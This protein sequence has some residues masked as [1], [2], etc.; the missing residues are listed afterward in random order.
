MSSVVKPILKTS[1]RGFD[2]DYLHSMSK[3][4]IYKTEYYLKD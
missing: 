4:N 3:L 2:M 1:K